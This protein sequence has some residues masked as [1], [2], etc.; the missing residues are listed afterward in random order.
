MH[1][2][3]TGFVAALLEIAAAELEFV[4]ATAEPCQVGD[5]AVVDLHWVD[6]RF[7]VR[8]ALF[9]SDLGNCRDRAVGQSRDLLVRHCDNAFRLPNT[10]G[11]NGWLPTSASARVSRS[12]SLCAGHV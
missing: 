8:Q 7:R 5:F 4:V 12:T 1:Q 10:L 6:V 3:A 9:P 2:Q 11:T